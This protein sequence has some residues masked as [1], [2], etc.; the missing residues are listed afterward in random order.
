MK[1]KEFKKV[2]Q[3]LVQ[4]G[5]QKKFWYIS[6]RLY[7]CYTDAYS[8]EKRN[9]VTIHNLLWPATDADGKEIWYEVPNDSNN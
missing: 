4:T 9:E 7:S 3:A 2:S 1:V 5:Y 8:Y 6:N